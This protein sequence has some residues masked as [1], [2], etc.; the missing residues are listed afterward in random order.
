MEKIVELILLVT[1][2]V[3]IVKV[4]LKAIINR[5]IKFWDKLIKLLLILALSWLGKRVLILVANKF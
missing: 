3:V 4:D 5:T 2:I 1:L